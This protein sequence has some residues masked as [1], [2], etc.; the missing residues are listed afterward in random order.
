MTPI[1]QVVAAVD[2][3]AG[4]L[5]H[6]VSPLALQQTDRLATGGYAAVDMVDA[7]VVGA[8]VDYVVTIVGDVLAT[9]VV[10]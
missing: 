4:S 6:L 10:A 8:G 1:V 7:F 5:A 2:P 3:I 9:A